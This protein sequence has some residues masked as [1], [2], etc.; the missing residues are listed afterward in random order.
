M[1]G[2]ALL[3]QLAITGVLF[4]IPV[5]SAAAA[6]YTVNTTDDGDDGSCTNPYVDASNDCTLHEA[7]DAANTNAGADTI[8]FSFDSSFSSTDEQWTIVVTTALP[9]VSEQVEITAASV[10]DNAG[11]I[12]NRPGVRLTTAL[13][14]SVSG[15]TVSASSVEV[16]GI[17]IDDFPSYGIEVSGGTASV[18]GTDCDA[19]A[20]E[21]ERNVIVNN[22]KSG[23]RLSASSNT[24]AGNYVG[25]AEDGA[26]AAPNGGST[27]FEAAIY[28]SGSTNV[29]GYSSSTCTAAA[30]RNIFS[31]NNL[32][33][34]HPGINIAA[35]NGNRISGNYIGTDASGLVAVGNGGD[36]VNMTGTSTDNIIGTNGDGV[37]DDKEGNV[38]SGNA[39]NGIFTFATGGQ[40]ISGGPD[41]NRFSGN[42]I[43]IG[44]DGST[45]VLNSGNGI[46][47][48]A[49]DNIY[50]WCDSSIDSSICSDAGSVADQRNWIIAGSGDDVIR[51]GIRADNAHINANKIGLLPAGG[52]PSSTAER[53]IGI[54]AR[55]LGHTIGG[56]DTSTGNEIANTGEGIAIMFFEN[57]NTN[58]AENI[59]IQNNTIYDNVAEGVDCIETMEYASGTYAYEVTFTGNTVKDNGTEGVRLRGCTWD[60]QNNTFQGNGGWGLRADGMERP[61]DPSDTGSNY[62]NPFDAPSPNNADEDLVSRPNIS[63]NTFKDNTNG[64]LYLFDTKAENNSSVITGNTFQQT[65]APA[66]T[67]TP[68]FKQVYRAAV[69]ILT[70]A[71]TP[72]TSGSETVTL[73]PADSRCDTLTGSTSASAGGSNAIWGKSGLTYN[74]A[75][76]W[77]TVTTRLH[78]A[79][80]TTSDCNPYSVRAL[81]TYTDPTATGY[82]FDGTDNDTVSTGGLVNGVT[83]NSVFRYQVAE[84]ITNTDADGDGIDNDTEIGNGTDP[85]NSDTDGDGIPDNEEGDSDSDGDG[86]PDPIDED[87]DDDGRPDEEEGTDDDD[88]DGIPNFQDPKNVAP[89]QPVNQSPVNGASGV[90]RTPTLISSVFIDTENDGHAKSFWKLYTSQVGCQERAIAGLVDVKSTTA[91]TSY[92]VSSG[93][94]SQNT[95]YWWTVAYQD[96]FTTPS[97]GDYSTCTSFTTGNGSPVRIAT[98]PFVSLEEDGAAETVFDLDTYFSDGNDELSYSV[99]ADAGGKLQHI[100]VTIGKENQVTMWSTDADWYG[101]EGVVFTAEDEYGASTDS[102]VVTVIVTPVNDAPGP[103][104]S[105]FS[106]SGG[107]STAAQYPIVS[108]SAASD[109]DN[110]ASELRYELH[111]GQS[112]NPA[113]SYDYNTTTS[114]GQT[115]VRL[116]IALND[117]TTYYYVVRTLDDGDAASDWS[118]VQSFEINLS[119]SPNMQLTKTA[120]VVN[121]SADTIGAAALKSTAE[122]SAIERY[123]KTIGHV[124]GT[125]A[126]VSLSI[127]SVV[128]ISLLALFGHPGQSLTVSLQTP[129]TAFQTVARQNAEGTFQES[130]TQFRR[131]VN[132]LRWILVGSI[133]AAVIFFALSFMAEAQEQDEVVHP[134]GTIRYVL[135]YSNSGNGSS[136]STVITDALPAQTSYVQD[137]ATAAVTVNDDGSVVFQLGSVAA[138]KSGT[139]A[140]DVLVTSTIED[141]LITAPSARLTSNEVAEQIAATADGPSVAVS[142]AA[143]AVSIVES[144]DTPVAH[145]VV[146]FYSPS[147]SEENKVAE[148]TTTEDGQGTVTGIQDGLYY[149]TVEPPVGY[150]SIPDQTLALRYDTVAGLRIEVAQE[151][152]GSTEEAA[153][154]TEAGIQV[155]GL[156]PAQ[157]DFL[158]ALPPLTLNTVTMSEEQAQALYAQLASATQDVHI[159]LEA[160]GA[161]VEPT[162]QNGAQVFELKRKY[163]VRDLWDKLLYGPAPFT[164][165]GNFTIGGTIELPESLQQPFQENAL[166]PRARVVLFSDPIVQLATVEDGK[167]S[168]T[169]PA[170]A[171]LGNEVHTVLAEFAING[172]SSGI[173]V[174]DQIGIIE[175]AVI[176][177]PTKITLVNLVLLLS[178]LVYSLIALVRTYFSSKFKKRKAFAEKPLREDQVSDQVRQFKQSHH[179]QD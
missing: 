62:N 154:I 144:D 147:I 85:R 58:P 43:G 105:G 14:G 35:G 163:G 129:S 119:K 82:S 88:E 166:E 91:L 150:A 138:G 167:W 77:F 103:P 68:G 115:S 156:T 72:I 133:L 151:G 89:D 65:S 33:S 165:Y 146:R 143:A 116:P 38:I 93:V 179:D 170:D 164:G 142:S 139:I 4:F 134:G 81:G 76:T 123:G 96:D 70:E 101:S 5:F 108:W 109:I 140:Y 48:R 176:P 41:G 30:Q 111:I 90:S 10:W 45:Q 168:V 61:D 74:D 84:V 52:T 121:G 86:D 106:P 6:T 69:E 174:V 136:T 160:E 162:N 83:T 18:I 141:H 42:Y 25:I 112:N 177:P 60:M 104:S 54:V 149:V 39:S 53:G 1:K 87:S 55:N 2:A 159:V 29:V 9:T 34:S 21:N 122:G 155:E 173:D 36:G 8:S 158:Q 16:K 175:K 15:L 79:D 32:L 130:Y 12:T 20:D 50:G 59:T 113:F 46:T 47:E 28:I 75:D 124:A 7:I 24:I 157:E 118:S 80:G 13:T 49:N 11:S 27:A 92:A 63:G 95:R 161:L 148:I 51:L 40:D 125:A 99:R 126:A 19:T 110:D 94:L 114:A 78:T 64:G 17:T 73:T 66:S 44:A 107:E 171:F 100:D 23:I 56:P 22:G 145:A 128:V 169:I 57:T 127:A 153:P 152:E 26:T 135:T 120:E 37:G 131:R 102:N 3:K 31:G 67:A 132:P 178:V 97:T 71:G 137:S 117:E 172:Q 98:L